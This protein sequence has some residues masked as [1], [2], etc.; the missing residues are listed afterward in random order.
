MAQAYR[1]YQGI[2]EKAR[3]RD[4]CAADSQNGAA[5]FP[6]KAIPNDRRQKQREQERYRAQRDKLVHRVGSNQE[7]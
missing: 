2:A 7:S 4:R 6:A 1:W 3:Q 5:R